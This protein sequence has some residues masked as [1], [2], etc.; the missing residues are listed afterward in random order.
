MFQ[1]GDLKEARRLASEITGKGATLYDLL[2]REVDLRVRLRACA[3][4]WTQ[5]LPSQ[6]RGPE[7]CTSHFGQSVFRMKVISVG[8]AADRL[9]SSWVNNVLQEN[10]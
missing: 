5:D 10:T 2:G 7:Y 4:F 6:P 1:I 9:L 8:A 3:M